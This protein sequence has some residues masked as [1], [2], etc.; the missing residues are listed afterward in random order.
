MT[1]ESKGIW[2][3]YFEQLE[4]IYLFLQEC[5]CLFSLNEPFNALGNPSGKYRGVFQLTQEQIAQIAPMLNDGK[6]LY[7]VASESNDG[8]RRELPINFPKFI[9]DDSIFKMQI[10][11]NKAHYSKNYT[12]DDGMLRLASVQTMILEDDD[13]EKMEADIKAFHEAGEALEKLGYEVLIENTPTINMMYIDVK[14]LCKLHQCNSV[15]HRI[16]TGRQIRAD[17]FSHDDDGNLLKS[18]LQSIGILLI[19]DEQQIA[20]IH[21]HDRK[22]R[23]DAIYTKRHPTEII[24]REVPEKFLTGRLYRRQ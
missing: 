15:Q 7:D 24:L 10:H 6:R 20:V 2:R 16:D 17:Y 23:T 21:S 18:K 3:V 14:T 4:E 9:D 13:A 1:K 22:I 5:R 11:I 19:P 12:P 8:K